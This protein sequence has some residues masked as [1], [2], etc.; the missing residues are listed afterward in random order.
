MNGNYEI[1]EVLNNG[2]VLILGTLIS[3]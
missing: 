2:D 3:K 1:I